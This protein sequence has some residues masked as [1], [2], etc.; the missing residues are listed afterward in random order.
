MLESDE[1]ELNIYITNSTS[2]IEDELT[3]YLE[4]KQ[5]DKKVSFK[6]LDFINIPLIFPY[7]L[8]NI[9]ILIFK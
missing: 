7:I 9:I 3:T 2:I 1:E 5:E 6:S 8:F 4:E